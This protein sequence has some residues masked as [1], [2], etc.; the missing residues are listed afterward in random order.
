M[1]V[2]FGRGSCWKYGS[3]SISFA[4]GLFDGSNESR[5][6]NKLAPAFVRVGNLDRTIEPRAALL[7]EGN[8]S[9][10]AFGSLLKP[11]QVSSVGIPQSSK[12]CANVN[13]LANTYRIG[14][15]QSIADWMLSSPCLVD[16]LRSCLAAVASW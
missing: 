2:G 15:F 10:R 14:P 11:G 3:C 1:A 8:L 6:L 13:K 9:E 5:L 4:D 16:P 12:I 7:F